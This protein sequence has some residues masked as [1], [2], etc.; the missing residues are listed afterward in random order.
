MLCTSPAF[1]IL[2]ATIALVLLF[3]LL[4]VYLLDHTGDIAPFPINSIM[5]DVVSGTL[6]TNLSHC[7]P[8]PSSA[9]GVTATVSSEQIKQERGSDAVSGSCI[10]YHHQ[11][12]RM[13]GQSNG[14]NQLLNCV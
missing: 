12:G 9:R 4:H 13:M 14:E 2:Q 10:I 3:N 1:I 7:S 8:A 5:E 6:L 11:A